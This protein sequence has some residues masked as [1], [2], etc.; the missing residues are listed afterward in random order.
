VSRGPSSGRPATYEDLLKVPEGKIA[1]IIDGELIVSP[2]PAPAHVVASSTLGGEL[3]GPFQRGK[4][5]PGG[6]WILDEP[7]LHL[8]R[9][10]L[11][12]DLGGWRR[13]RL[14]RMP[15]TAWFELRPDWV[16]EVI[17]P[18][19]AHVDRVRK[20]RIYAREGVPHAWLVDPERRTHEVFTL[21]TGVFALTHAFEGDGNVRAP[22][23]DAIE[24][25][26]LA[27]WGGEPETSGT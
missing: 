17:S 3:S 16:C 12:P 20:L 9:D 18:S 11:V 24:L 25:E 8:G 6:W 10:I 27:L 4:G 21:Q 23:F 22:P 19:S 2:R 14:A 15:E 7:E 5:G 13:D 1:E 26:L